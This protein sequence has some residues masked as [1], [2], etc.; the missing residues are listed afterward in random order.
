MMSESGLAACPKQH[1]VFSLLFIRRCFIFCLL[2]I[3]AL[4]DCLIHAAPPSFDGFFPA[5]I[6]RGMT[7]VVSVMGKQDTW[8]SKVWVS[9]P[10]ITFTAQTNRG[11]FRVY[12]TPDTVPGPRL[13]RLY[14]DEG[15]SEPR[16]FVIDAAIPPLNIRGR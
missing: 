10:Q 15:S 11:K 3:V 12:P 13:V 1:Q 4:G 16:I 14:N 2:L 7:N 8:P 9:D 5:G 6:S